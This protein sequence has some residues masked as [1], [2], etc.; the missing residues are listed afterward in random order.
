LI[1]NFRNILSLKIRD[2][3]GVGKTIN[4][5][6]KENISK[7]AFDQGMYDFN[8]LTKFR[9]MCRNAPKNAIDSIKILIPK[10][11]GSFSRDSTDDRHILS[12][13]DHFCRRP[14]NIA[15]QNGNLEIVKYLI[16]N[17]AKN[18]TDFAA[19]DDDRIQIKEQDK[20]QTEIPLCTAARW[21]H[22]MIVEYLVN[23]ENYPVEVLLLSRELS[24]SR[25]VRNFLEKALSSKG[26]AVKKNPWWCCGGAGRS[27]KTLVSSYIEK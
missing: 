13:K 27:E 11:K 7:N 24:D 19:N 20:Y 1:E 8:V 4:L 21:N 10:A 17:G 14:M 18:Q 16:A 22:L 25:L 3:D 9:K 2:V 5:M 26:H 15:C 6:R 23:N 12:K